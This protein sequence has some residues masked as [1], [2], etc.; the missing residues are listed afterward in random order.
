MTTVSPHGVT[1][2][3]PTPAGPAVD[4]D[5]L[6]ATGHRDVS[7]ADPLVRGDL[8]GRYVILSYLGHG[9]MSIVYAAYDPEL[10]RKVALKLLKPHQDG[11]RLQRE[12]QAMAQLSHPCIGSA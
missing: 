11:Q 10:D 4:P 8:V 6:A 7:D 1:L 9:G 3:S 5:P 2:T 12:A